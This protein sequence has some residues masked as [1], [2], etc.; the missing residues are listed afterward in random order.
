MPEEVIALPDPTACQT[1]EV[2]DR[3]YVGVSARSTFIKSCFMVWH[4]W[5]DARKTHRLLALLA[6]SK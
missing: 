5:L 2:F 1:S 3:S 6:W 4:V